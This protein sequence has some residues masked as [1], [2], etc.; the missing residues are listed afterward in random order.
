MRP[1][2]EKGVA[3]RVLLIGGASL[4]L[5]ACGEG[6]IGPPPA[7]TLYRIAP[8][9][10]SAPGAGAKVAWALAIMRPNM[11]AG[12]DV[13]RIALIQPDGTL[14][15]Y[16]KANYPDRLA[17]MV[18]QAILN[19]FE[20][21]GRID[22]VALEQDALHADYYL[23]IEVKDFA[24]HYS[25]SDGIPAARVSIT[26]KLTTAHGRAIVGSFSSTKTVTA[27]LNSTTAVAQAL[28]QALGQAVPDIANWTLAAPMPSAQTANSSS[29]K[30]AEELLRDMTQSSAPARN[31]T[32]Q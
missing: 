13:D 28:Q 15:Y 14:D 32:P 9:F 2:M 8:D 29:A 4:A 30:P 18:Q 27:S 6:L 20:A 22:A 3:R 7:G 21:S 12:L 10:A 19:G 5:S 17:V 25:E 16:A 31:N 1:R 26:V 23:D 24:A 11:T